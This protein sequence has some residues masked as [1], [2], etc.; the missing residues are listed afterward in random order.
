MEELY[1]AIEDRIKSSGYTGKV[2]GAWIYDD[3]CDQIDDKENGD[4]I[5]MSKPEDDILY[6]YKITIGDEDFNLSS[7]RITAPEG[8]FT[9]D[10][11]N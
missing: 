2:D 1:R 8:E 4:Y 6:E 11:D 3:I 9:I 7:M 10:F 5:L